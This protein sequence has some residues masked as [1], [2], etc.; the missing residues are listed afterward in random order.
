MKR[1][2]LLL[3]AALALTACAEGSPGTPGTATA[4]LDGSADFFAGV[5]GSH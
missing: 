5:G 2:F 4:H 3:F 1:L